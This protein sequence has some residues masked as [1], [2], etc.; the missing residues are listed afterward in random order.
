MA[1]GTPPGICKID[2]ILSQPSVE[3][4]DFIGTPITG[5]LVKAA[6]IPGKCAAPPAPAIITC[7]PLLRAV[8]A[9]STIRS[10]VRCAETTVNSKGILKVFKVSAAACMIGKSLSLPIMIP[11]CAGVDIIFI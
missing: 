3:L 8:F 7:K 6:T 5:K 10:G 1:T 4:V 2:N 11:T 9:Y